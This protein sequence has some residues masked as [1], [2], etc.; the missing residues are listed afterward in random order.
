MDPEKFFSMIG[1]FVSS[2]WLSSHE[3]F[4]DRHDLF[5]FQCLEMAGKVAVG[6]TEKVLQGIEADRVVHHE[7][8][9]DPKPYPALE[10]FLKVMY[11]IFHPNDFYVRILTYLSY[12]KYMTVPYTICIIPN[13][14]IQK[15]IP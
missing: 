14:V 8:R 5:L 10:H 9:H 7:C 12:R 1:G 6:E 4:Q 2:A 15:S 11:W 3:L 13:P